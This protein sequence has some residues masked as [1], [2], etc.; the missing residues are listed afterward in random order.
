MGPPPEPALRPRPE[1]NTGRPRGWMGSR[2][3]RDEVGVTGRRRA[4]GQSFGTSRGPGDVLR[5]QESWSCLSRRGKRRRAGVRFPAREAPLRAPPRRLLPVPFPPCGLASASPGPACG[6][7]AR[8]AKGAPPPS[9]PARTAPPRRGNVSR[10]ASGSSPTPGPL[11]R[12]ACAL[13]IAP[14][15]ASETKLY[16]AVTSPSARMGTSRRFLLSPRRRLPPARHVR[17]FSH[18]SKLESVFWADNKR[19]R[20]PKLS[21]ISRPSSGPGLRNH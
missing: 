11:S 4:G 19:V 2:S 1:V 21:F 8:G 10:R 15:P 12:G 3:C 14:E 18:P 7:R 5:L 6:R 20:G 16:C 9:P 13:S 17:R